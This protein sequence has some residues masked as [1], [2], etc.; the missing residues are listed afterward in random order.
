MLRFW[1]IITCSLALLAGCD[2]RPQFRSTDITGVDYGN[3]LELTDHTGKLR[4][5]E[6]FRG[7]AVVLFFGFTQCPDVCPTTLAE[8]AGAVK[9]LGA[10]A[11]RVQVLLVTVDPERDTPKLL[12]EYVTAFDPR[13]LAL[14]GDLPA[15]QRVAKEFK[16]YFEKRKTGSSYTIDHSAQSYVIDPQGRLRLLVRHDRIGQDLVDDLRTLLRS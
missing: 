6:D 16:I 8:I 9:K 7:K 12:A 3:T 2:S 10:D 4:H 1:S 15:T 11:D 5:L 14:R 13:F